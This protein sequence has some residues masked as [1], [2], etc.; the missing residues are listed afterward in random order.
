MFFYQLALLEKWHYQEKQLAVEKLHSQL[1]VE[2]L[3]NKISAELHDD[4]GSTLSGISMYSHMA[5]GLLQNSDYSKAKDAVSVIQKSANDIVH[6]L[7]DLVW[8]I[9]PEKDSMA[10]ML[11]R[12]EKYGIEM[13]DAKDMKFQCIVNLAGAF[14]E[15]GMEVRQHLLML[16]KEAINNAVKYSE[17]TVVKFEATVIEG[18]LQVSVSDNGNGFDTSNTVSGNGLG[19]MAKR[20]QAIGA[21]L[22]IESTKA[23]GTTVKLKI[24]MT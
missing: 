18:I 19:N 3:R 16:V 11:E 12:I 22:F 4:I 7:G 5:D 2:K 15:P 24:K 14:D 20:A 17:A 21:A 8:A 10:I 9:N 1:E 13:C 23:V 6:R